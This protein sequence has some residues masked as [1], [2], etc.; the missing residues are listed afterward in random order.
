MSEINLKHVQQKLYEKLDAA[1]WGKILRSFVLSSEFYNILD[2]LAI[3]SNAGNNFTPIIKNIFKAFEECPY[4]KLSVIVIGQDPYPKQ[5]VADGIAFS[6]SNSPEQSLIQYIWTGLEGENISTDR[7]KNLARW[8]NQGVLML[9]SALTTQI[10]KVGTHVELWKPF[11]IYLLDMLNS[12]NTGLV[13]IFMGKSAEF[14]VNYVDQDMNYPLL[15]S[16]PATAAYNRKK[17]WDSKGVFT[18]TNRILKE[19]N[20][21]GIKW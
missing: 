14:F 20:N 18:E 4:D 13:Y 21:G 9:N 16:H 12:H 5:D 8:S 19:L 7:D 3:E 11:M 15:T 1:G 10:G 17:E 2:R 6:C